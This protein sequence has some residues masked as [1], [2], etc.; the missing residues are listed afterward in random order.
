[1]HALASGSIQRKFPAIPLPERL[2]FQRAHETLVTR[3]ALVQ[4]RQRQH[5][6]RLIMRVWRYIHI[7]LACMALLI[8]SYHGVMELLTNVFHIIAAQ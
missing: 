3:A 2:D 6:A 7:T 8:I 1:M 4:S 5:H